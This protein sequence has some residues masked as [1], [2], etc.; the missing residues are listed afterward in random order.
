MAAYKIRALVTLKP[1]VLDPQGEAIRRALAS[2]AEAGA[3][4]ASVRQG[5]LFDLDIDAE[6]REAAEAAARRACE[7]LLANE[8]MERFEILQASGA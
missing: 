2:D 7:R 8:V 5:K 4:F 3:A 1:S 6:S